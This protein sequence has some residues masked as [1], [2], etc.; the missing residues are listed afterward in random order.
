MAHISSYSTPKVPTRDH[1]AS[2]D[3]TKNLFKLQAVG[4]NNKVF[5]KELK[6]IAYGYV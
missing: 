1:S 3:K 5:D 4:A 6:S 2:Q